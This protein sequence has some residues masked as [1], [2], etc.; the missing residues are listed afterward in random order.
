MGMKK[1]AELFIVMLFVVAF[2][3]PVFATSDDES[4][5]LT[6]GSWQYDA[7]A[8]LADKGH[9]TDYPAGLGGLPIERDSVASMLAG[10]L[11]VDMTQVSAEDADLL[12]RLVDEFRSELSNYG[13]IEVRAL[14]D[15]DKLN[16][17]WL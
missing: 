7:V 5:N 1:F 3:I 16:P 9:F 2:A 4:I 10:L 11:P 14:D 12:E 8:R 15:V 13:V 6:A 17:A